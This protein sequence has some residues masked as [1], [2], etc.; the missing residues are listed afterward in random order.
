MVTI[1]AV[2]LA[3]KYSNK[4][5]IALHSLL[6]CDEIILLTD[7]KDISKQLF[8]TKTL[9]KLKIVQAP[10]LHDFSKKRNI[11]LSHAHSDWVLFLDSDETV[12]NALKT[13]I[14]DAVEQKDI[15]GFFIKREDFFM[16]KVLKRGDPSSVMLLRLARKHAGIWK[17]PVH[18]YWDVQKKTD[19]LTNPILHVP[20]DSIESFLEKINMYTSIESTYRKQSGEQFSLF[21]LFVFPI[22]KFMYSYIFQLG[23]LDGFAGFTMAYMMSVHS[24][25]VRVKMYEK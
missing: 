15:H 4:L 12:S 2:V 21:E 1:S 8:D 19:I 7:T 6:F 9:H 17:R 23:F 22:I 16:N 18:E 5:N 13:E 25:C 11:G 24:L 20:H 14:L 10:L 3:H